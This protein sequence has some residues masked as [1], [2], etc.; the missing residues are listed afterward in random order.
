MHDHVALALV[1][2]ATDKPL[3]QIAR[4]AAVAFWK[5]DQVLDAPNFYTY[6]IGVPFLTPENAAKYP[7]PS[8]AWTLFMGMRPKSRGSIHLTGAKASDPLQI[9][10]NYLSDPSDL[11]DLT[12][13][14]QC[15]RE[16]G[17]AAALHPYTKREHAANLTGAALEE[18]IRNGLVTFW[19]QSGTA[20]MGR[21][22]MSVVDNE[23]KVYGVEGLRIADASILP[24]VT[25]GNTMAPCVIIGERAAELLQSAHGAK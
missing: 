24:R 17:N 6:G 16:I 7:P 18:Y 1:W 13:G 4:S 20:K 25:T 11:K 21:D 12:L 14:V 19:H 23:L 3:P 10:A 22:S 9:Q 5:T 2:E 8:A 15:A